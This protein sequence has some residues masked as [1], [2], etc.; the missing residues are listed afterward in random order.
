[1]HSQTKLITGAVLAASLAAADF[2]GASALKYTQQ[3]VSFGPRPPASAAI[4]KTRQYILGELRKLDVSA[5]EDRFTGKTPRG[6]MAMANIIA[7]IPGKSGRVIVISGHYDTKL[8]PGISFVGANDGGS[9]AG[10]LLELAR[11][12]AGTSRKD[13][14]WL[15]WF[16][17]EE[18]IGEWS[19]T[20]GLHGSRH[21]AERWSNDGSLARIKA[22]I[23]VDMI[24][25]KDLGILQEYQSHEGIRGLVWQSAK[26]LGYGR[27]FLEQPSFVED[28]HVPFLRR[29]VRAID[30]IDFN[31]GPGN[32]PGAYW[33]T[34]QDTVDKLSANSFD[35]VG[36]VLLE[37][38]KRLEAQ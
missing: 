38:I 32:S 1:M 30:L 4:V 20:D 24:G 13:D 6:P 10:L 22:L 14:V 27:Y 2:S 12:L 16:D 36:R 28:D 17:G 5:S 3:I 25:D 11:S 35:V 9:S 33:H 31:Y 18:A 21:L 29:G 15:A 8:M 7:R 26:D 34:P 19:A 23:N 37:V